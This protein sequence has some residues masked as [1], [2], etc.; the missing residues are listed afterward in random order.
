MRK[1]SAVVSVPGGERVVNS[2][3]GPIIIH[4]TADQTNGTIGIFEGIIA[5][6]E[7]V[8]EHCHSREDETFRVVSGH[9]RFFIGDEVIDGGAGATLVAPR[10]VSHRWVNVSD[11]EARLLCLV[12]P[13]GFEGFF[14]DLDGKHPPN[15]EFKAICTKYGLRWSNE[16]RDT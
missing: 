13:G 16:E 5:P 4:A 15:K 12:T 6:G 2:P 7:A 10:G 14:I 11:T 3:G 1:G 8:P 9:F